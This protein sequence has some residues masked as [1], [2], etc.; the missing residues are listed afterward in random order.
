MLHGRAV[1]G[2]AWASLRPVMSRA[3]YPLVCTLLGLLLGWL[4]VLLHGPIAHKFN[5]LYID[6]ATAVWAF[7]LSRLTVGFWVGV[8]VWP[9]AWYVRGPLFGFLA[10]LPVSLISLA[11]PGCGFT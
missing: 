8:A 1:V 3:P 9:R 4:P 2:E 5:V 11:T 6:G 7:Y 10:L